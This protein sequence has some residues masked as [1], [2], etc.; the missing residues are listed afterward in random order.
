[1]KTIKQFSDD[2]F[3]SRNISKS[4]GRLL[5]QYRITTEEYLYLD[6][7]CKDV[8]RINVLPQWFFLYGV[9]TWRR[10]YDGSNRSWLYTN[11]DLSQKQI[12]SFI[13]GSI[14]YWQIE[15][16]KSSKKTSYLNTLAKNAGIPQLQVKQS[17]FQENCNYVLKKSFVEDLSQIIPEFFNDKLYSLD[18]IE[19]FIESIK[20]IQADYDLFNKNNPYQY[21]EYEH[22]GWDSNLPV[23]VRD[24]SIESFINNLFKSANR[25]NTRKSRSEHINTFNICDVIDVEKERSNIVVYPPKVLPAKYNE[26]FPNKRR[27]RIHLVTK[28]NIDIA[29]YSWCEETL[30]FMMDVKNKL[31]L[32]SCDS[33]LLL[34]DS[35]NSIE[36]KDS[37]LLFYGLESDEQDISFY[38]KNKKT[39]K[40]VSNAS[41]SKN[42][43][44]I[45]IGIKSHVQLI[46]DV[47][48]KQ[49]IIYSDN[50]GS[51]LELEGDL[52]NWSYEIDGDRYYIDT[53][54][55]ES[56]KTIEQQF[57]NLG[58][59]IEDNNYH[60]N[61]LN[62]FRHSTNFINQSNMYSINN[63]KYGKYNWFAVENGVRLARRQ[64][65]VFPEN[66]GINFDEKMK[67][68]LIHGYI[69]KVEA[70]TMRYQE[71]LCLPI[72]NDCHEIDLSESTFDKFI[73][74][75]WLNDLDSCEIIVEPPISSL[76]LFND[77]GIYSSSEASC[78]D[79]RYLRLKGKT[80]SLKIMINQEVI[81]NGEYDSKI[82]IT[83]YLS[84][85]T[86]QIQKQIYNNL[87]DYMHLIIYDDGEIIVNLRINTY[88][89][90]SDFPNHSN[91]INYLKDD[92]VWCLDL[93]KLDDFSIQHF[94]NLDTKNYYA[95]YPVTAI[96]D[97]DN[98][99]KPMYVG[100]KNRFDSIYSGFAFNKLAINESNVTLI[101]N[102]LN[103]ISANNINITVNILE[104]LGLIGY[105]SN[106]LDLAKRN[107]KLLLLVANDDFNDNNIQ[108]L[109][110]APSLDE[111]WKD[112]N[113]LVENSNIIY[114]ILNLETKQ[115][116][117]LDGLTNA[118]ELLVSIETK[119]I[120]KKK[121]KRL[122][123]RDINDLT[124]IAKGTI[125]HYKGKKG[126]YEGLSWYDSYI[127]IFFTDENKTKKWSYI[128][129]EAL[130]K[131]SLEIED[132]IKE[133]HKQIQG[134]DK[135]LK[136]IKEMKNVIKHNTQSSKRIILDNRNN[137]IT[138]TILN[139]ID[140]V[141]SL[142]V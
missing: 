85:F 114:N 7:F 86:E 34:K 84:D 92:Y 117:S 140:Y 43:S 119:S 60:I 6:S 12:K 91:Y 4:D 142:E 111:L 68:C 104:R 139:L 94:K 25:Y 70:I 69:H 33:Y 41:I 38:K 107:I 134:S 129:P 101:R 13:E 57:S 16:V 53:L 132:G 136:I 80:K 128:S 112:L 99:Y 62:C 24:D 118:L 124:Q 9:E 135:A 14:N 46:N 131:I 133:Y 81:F 45:F 82:S 138:N 103:I 51:L 65:W 75:V 74:R 116:T 22:S 77:E 58:N 50:R 122:K 17:K 11:L 10:K 15:L 123:L 3:S 96:S 44:E 78:S 5:Y 31:H 137:E 126:I 35:L 52:N 89:Y 121:K 26:F 30:S 39:G 27:Q 1:M 120:T 63:A 55:T 40:Y 47:G 98:Y 127:N 56:Q 76:R 67:K 102:A 97:G 87:N 113:Y 115:N 8:K 23:R 48:D 109:M 42:S 36:I 100:D 37:D 73:I 29:K 32:N 21:L 141:N 125:C 110:S 59:K 90:Q 54:S 79:L 83:K 64:L 28:T 18:L 61:V 88:D 66:F 105:F 72:S 106:L 19:S 20:T 95:V 108:D 49:R 71:I 2:F 130:D 93:F